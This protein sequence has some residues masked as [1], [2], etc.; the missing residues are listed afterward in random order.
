MSEGRQTVGRE[1]GR[2]RPSPSFPETS[3]TPF[4]SDL[5]LQS[6]V[7]VGPGVSAKGVRI[8]G[9]SQ[10]Q[11]PGGL[12]QHPPKLVPV[13]FGLCCPRTGTPAAL[14]GAGPPEGL[15]LFPLPSSPLP[16]D[17]KSLCLG[18]LS[19]RLTP[20]STLGLS[21]LQIQGGKILADSLCC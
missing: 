20:L 17:P 18:P 7:R 12:V 16:R 19:S 1:P 10:S 2:R 13:G 9:S 15:Q 4:H 8:W 14:V 11:G 3:L 21:L 6:A 5:G